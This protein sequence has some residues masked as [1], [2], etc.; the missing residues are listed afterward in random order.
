MHRGSP[1]PPSGRVGSNPLSGGF[2]ALVLC[3][4]GALSPAAAQSPPPDPT[5]RYNAEYRKVDARSVSLTSRAAGGVGAARAPLVQALGLGAGDD[6]VETTRRLDRSGNRHIRYQQT[7]RGIPIYGSR[8]SLHERVGGATVKATGTIIQ[9]LAPAASSTS[10][11]PPTARAP[12]ISEGDALDRARQNRGHSGA[13]WRISGVSVE[14]VLYVDGDQPPREVY[15]VNYFA[16]H[17]TNPPTRPFLLIDANTAEIVQAYEGLAHASATGPGGNTK[18]GGYEFGVDE[19]AL[20]VEQV[21]GLCQLRNSRVTTVDMNHESTTRTGPAF[22]FECPRNTHEPINGASSPLNDLH[23]LGGLTVDLFVELFGEP[24]LHFPPILRA[25][26]GSGF[27]NAF[28][29][30]TSS[31]F[32]DGATRF[33]PLTGVNIVAHEISHG[34]TEQNSNLI[35]VSQSGGINESFSD[36]AGEALEY[37]WKGEVDWF[38]GGAILKQGDGLRYFEDPTRDGR[39]IGH[40]DDF[41]YFLDVHYSSGVFNRAYFLLSNTPGWDPKKAFEVFGHANQ[42][43]W[44]PN[45]TFVTGACGALEAAADLFYSVADV[46]AAFQAVGV[47][48]GYVPVVD[49]D[50]DGMDDNWELGFGLDPMNPADAAFDLDS[51]ELSNLLEFRSES[52]PSVPDT[53][54]DGLTDGAEYH[55]HG[56]DLLDPDSDDDGLPDGTEVDDT[57]TDPAHSDS[58]RDGLD[59]G[60]ELSTHGTDPLVLDTDGDGLGDGFEIE[61]GFDP[62]EGGDDVETDT[63]EDG[64]TLLEEFLNGANPNLVDSDADGLSDADEV[65]TLG[66]DPANPDSDADAMTDGFEAAHGLDPT[67]DDAS[68]D[69]DNDGFSNLEEFFDGSDP[70]DASSQ[71]PR[72][73]AYNFQPTRNDTE[74]L[75]RVDLRSGTREHIARIPIIRGIG[76]AALAPNRKI[77]VLGSSPHVLYEVDPD[78]GRTRVVGSTGESHGLGSSSNWGLAADHDGALWLAAAHEG[79]PALYRLDTETGKASLIGSMGFGPTAIAKSLAFDG[80]DLYALVEDSHGRTGLYII[81]RDSGVATRVGLVDAPQAN[82]ADDGIGLVADPRGNLFM[83]LGRSPVYRLDKHTGLVIHE[84]NRPLVDFYVTSMTLYSF[85]NRD[86]DRDGM[87]DAWEIEHG[88]DPDDASDLRLDP[89]FDG[90]HNLDEFTWNTDPNDPDG[91]ADGLS[92]GQEVHRYGTDPRNIDTDLDAMFDGWEIESGL[93]PG[94]ADAELDADDDS[95]SNVQEFAMGSDPN[96]AASEPDELVGYAGVRSRSIDRVNLLT[97]EQTRIAD[98]SIYVDALRIAMDASGELYAI[99]TSGNTPS[100]LRIDTETGEFYAIGHL[101]IHGEVSGMAFDSFNVLWAADERYIYRV[102]TATGDATVQFATTHGSGSVTSIAAGVESIYQFTKDDLYIDYSAIFAITNRADQSSKG[103]VPVLVVGDF[104][105]FLTMTLDHEQRLL[106]ID[107][108]GRVVR[109]LEETGTPI[110]LALFTSYGVGLGGLALPWFVDSD[111]D[112]LSD[113]VEEHFGLDPLDGSDALDDPD[114]DTLSNVE[115]VGLGIHPDT[116]DTDRDGL[117]DDEEFY[118]LF[119][120][121]LSPDTDADGVDDGL[122]VLTYGSDPLVVDSDED[123]ISDGDEVSEFGTDPANPDSDADGMPDG[124]ERI[125][126]LNLL[127]D[128][129]ELDFDGDGLSNADEHAFGTRPTLPDSDY[130]TISDGDEVHVYG[131]NPRETD[132][133]GDGISDPVEIT[134][135]LDPATSDAAADPDA[136]EWANLHESQWGTDPFD[137]RS[138]PSFDGFG[139]SHACYGGV[140]R[141]GLDTGSMTAIRYST[142]AA[143][144]AIAFNDEDELYV[145]DPARSIYSNRLYRSKIRG[146]RASYEAV[147]PFSLSRS[148]EPRGIAFDDAGVLWILSTRDELTFLNRFDSATGFA[149]R[150]ATLDLGEWQGKSLAWDGESLYAIAT[151]GSEPQFPKLYQIDSATGAVSETATLQTE[152]ANLQF[153][154]DANRNGDLYAMVDGES[155]VRIDKTTG[156]VTTIATYDFPGSVGCSTTFAFNLPTD[157]DDDG[158]PDYWE[159][160]NGFDKTDPDDAVGDLDSDGISNRGEYDSGTDPQDP[161]GDDDGLLDGD[162]GFEHGTDPYSVDT[163]GDEMP[164]HWE[165]ENGTD[166]LQEDE[167]GDLDGDLL[168]NWQEYQLGTHAGDPDS[169]PATESGYVIFDY[170]HLLARLDF[171]SGNST[172]IGVLGNDGEF[173]TLAVSP[174]RELYSIS[175]ADNRL[176]RIDAYTAEATAIGPAL[177]LNPQDLAFDRE[178]VLWTISGEDL[179]RIDVAAGVV[180]DSRSIGSGFVALTWSEGALYAIQGDDSQLFRIDPDDATTTFIDDLYLGGRHLDPTLVTD[181]QGNLLRL[182]STFRIYGIDK[183]TG[184]ETELQRTLPGTPAVTIAL[185]SFSGPDSN[186]DGV[187]DYWELAYGL[188]PDDANL[189]FDSDGLSD[190]EE[191]FARSNPTLGDTDRDGIDDHTEVAVHGTDPTLPD[192]DGDGT[193]DPTELTLG[194]DP[195][196]EDSDR[197]NDGDGWSNR[198]E[199]LDGSDPE[200]FASKPP[201]SVV[202]SYSAGS[203]TYPDE[204]YE[205]DLRSGRVRQLAAAWL[206]GALVSIAMDS[207]HRLYA[208]AGDGQLYLV[209]L[210][211]GVFSPIGASMGASEN[212]SLTFDPEDRLWMLRDELLYEVDPG[213]AQTTL[214]DVFDGWDLAQIAWSNGTLY[215]T[216]VGRPDL[217]YEL[218]VG[219]S[220]ATLV[221]PFGVH[222][223][224]RTGITADSGGALWG[225]LNSRVILRID[226]TTGQA[227]EFLSRVDSLNRF[228]YLRGIAIYGHDDRDFDGDGLPNYWEARFGFDPH[229]AADASADPDFDG[230][231]NEQEYRMETDPTVSNLAPVEDFP[232]AGGEGTPSQVPG[233]SPTAI[234]L[235]AASLIGS[236]CALGRRR[237][238]QRKGL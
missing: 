30:G 82:P 236:G 105:R 128:D 179:V 8:I 38:Q 125:H 188:D 146:G 31:A 115:E 88:L 175:T 158:L 139:Y 73:T 25:H 223:G 159:D 61:F 112:G 19:P 72:L 1:R 154:L 216:T 12:S 219:M 161:D 222:P 137:P 212:V 147:D 201:E 68:L 28:W 48:C 81:G 80:S 174:T 194:T 189:D 92:D 130:D 75:Y 27:D 200:D 149:R 86:R 220:N 218:D 155:V 183:E 148:E 143:A 49:L 32:G 129:G 15:S 231:T 114:G 211:S 40:A 199:T 238:N 62:L 65:Q 172:V 166:P 102:D 10:S 47:D 34:F 164:D 152:Y 162:E 171:A 109:I 41:H 226:P 37:H 134:L 160:E 3:L 103:G 178:G 63:D 191:Y 98:F 195:L 87:A 136:D 142:F 90:L 44:E 13:G 163:D 106:G 169:R 84:I 208:A 157:T 5:S 43:Y 113:H 42:F 35:Y 207:R 210:A 215:G 117:T 110:Q 16:G 186:G 177:G 93:N 131:S 23:Y 2:V 51:D 29:D 181:S 141:L 221:G 124:W 205:V 184:D 64:L 17:D 101:G 14:L 204:V 151:A 53:D 202:Y 185:H 36:M 54:A 234:A 55:V 133:D 60:A 138:K 94:L 213:T 209:N 83:V 20:E 198:Q 237:V 190:R 132:S 74:H 120:D 228:L 167:W 22:E 144:T 127:E 70:S 4:L 97:G 122:E 91:D 107:S 230:L 57:N 108:Y 170:N 150:I 235:L 69:L 85:P 6:L 217:L 203:Y 153:G 46:N 126:D 21:G 156:E 227:F 121:P 176:Y 232:A 18:T 11:S 135:G 78:S 59:D 33:Y 182:T 225:R 104:D 100:L 26:F 77:Y 233:L 66:T 165:V 9:D 56:T 229:S 193:A 76:G 206:P 79:D 58:D 116:T 192:S 24:P 50:R 196:L 111:A 119:T 71:P 96:D 145:I 180:I 89:D 187:P 197:D 7:H 173:Q 168:T 67:N 39:S 214:I 224:Y 52:D 118:V 123:G 45:A 140:H 99:T 95:W